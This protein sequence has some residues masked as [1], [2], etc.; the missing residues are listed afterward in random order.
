MM[1]KLFAITVLLVLVISACTNFSG[2]RSSESKRM[3]TYQNLLEK[4]KVKEIVNRLFI[5]TDN[6]DWDPVSQL[7][8][9]EVLF[10]MT[11]MVGGKPVTLTPQEIVASWEKGLKPL[12]AIHHQAGNYIVHVNQKEAEV[13][14]YGIASHY[15][16][17]KTNQNTRIFVGSYNFHLIKNGE[18][19]QIDKFKFNL[20][21]IDGNL[22]LEASQ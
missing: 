14:C 6:R 1:K 7:F 19:W 4:D 13:F 15:L 20:K 17:N 18:V 21:Y 22:K 3:S 2:N 9:Q 16:P 10:D 11:S 8:A 5:S 12:K